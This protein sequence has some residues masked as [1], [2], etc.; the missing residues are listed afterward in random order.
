M[1]NNKFHKIIIN[2]YSWNSL[3]LLYLVIILLLINLLL[4]F[5]NKFAIKNILIYLKVLFKLVTIK[6]TII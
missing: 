6:F 2:K 1:Y 3:L 4:N 5:Q